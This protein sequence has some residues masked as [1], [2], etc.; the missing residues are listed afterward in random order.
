MKKTPPPN[1][2][3]HVKPSTR[4]PYPLKKNNPLPDFVAISLYMLLR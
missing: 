2:C 3:P 4:F 1:Q